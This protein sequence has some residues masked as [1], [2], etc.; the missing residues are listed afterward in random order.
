MSTTSTLDFQAVIPIGGRSYR[1]Q[2]ANLLYPTLFLTAVGNPITTDR[3]RT[4][5]E[6]YPRRASIEGVRCSPHTF[7]HTFNISY[8][9]AD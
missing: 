8:L 4:I 6:K 5:I 9:P 3:L 1:P 7:R 2:P